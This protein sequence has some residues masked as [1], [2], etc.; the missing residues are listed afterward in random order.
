MLMAS[1]VL[2]IKTFQR[3]SDRSKLLAKVFY[4]TFKA[5]S[6]NDGTNMA[7]SISFYILLSFIPLLLLSISI[8]GFFAGNSPAHFDQIFA[9]IRIILPFMDEGVARAL[10]KT[11]AGKRALG[12]SSLLVLLWSVNKIFSSSERVLNRIFQI[13]K[14]RG[15]VMANLVSLGLALALGLSLVLSVGVGMLANILENASIGLLP[16]RIGMILNHPLVAMWLPLVLLTVSFTVLIVIIPHG[17]V[18]SRYAILGGAIFATLFELAKNL[19]TYY[20]MKVSNVSLIYGSFGSIIIII[21][22]VFYLSILFIF[23]AEFVSVVQFW[24][25]EERLQISLAELEESIPL[26]N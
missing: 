18:Y 16:I 14:G 23:S 24:G 4:N 9:K 20:I 25:E 12:G 10:R 1:R 11:V 26:A 2:I 13:K 22:W 15:F 5:F 7:A 21:L 8:L 17:K 3:I 19:F 6:V